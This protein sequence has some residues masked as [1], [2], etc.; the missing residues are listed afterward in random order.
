MPVV[1]V[2]NLSKRYGEHSAVVDVSFSVEQG[3]VVAVLGP[4]GAGKTTTMEILEGFLKRSGGSA[5]V[6]GADPGH[7]GSHWRSQIGMVLQATSLDGAL[8]VG[9]TVDL[10][11]GLYPAPLPAE[12]V[13]D[14]V[15]LAG[16]T[17]TRVDQLSGGQQRRVDLAVGIVGQPK[18]LFL[19]EPTTG[20]D[21]DA[22]EHAWTTV[23]DLTARGTTVLLTTHYLEEARRLA[24]R[25][26]VLAE[27]RVIAD[28]TPDRIT[29]LMERSMVI[30]F[31][32]ADPAKVAELPP[33]LGDLAEPHHDEVSIKVEDVHGA[34]KELMAWSDAH[35]EQL[36][37][38]TVSPPSLESVYLEI[39]HRAEQEASSR[40]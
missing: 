5:E 35:D 28:D 21:P 6:L 12:D 10:Y 23:E 2:R 17:K 24:G 7:A 11:A 1:S 4:N 18:V 22:R 29:R 39:V 38:L 16:E 40:A 9:E 3:E 15:G 37:G 19:D 27:G 31:R 26:I 8:T 14:M 30:N 36:A 20:F 25:I 32:L 33:A 13:L 34:L